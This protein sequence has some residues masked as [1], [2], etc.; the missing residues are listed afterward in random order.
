MTKNNTK[1]L[2]F[3]TLAILQLKKFDDYESIY[4][5]NPLYLLNNHANGY[6]EKKNGN[7]YLVF[8]DSVDENKIKAINDDEENIYEKDYMK[9]NLILMMIYH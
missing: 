2:A 4:C 3:T 6:I 5:A 7:K 9:I 1:T 8:N